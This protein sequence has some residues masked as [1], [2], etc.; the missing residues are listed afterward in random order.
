MEN[1]ENHRI[2]TKPFRKRVE[3]MVENLEALF[4]PEEPSRIGPIMPLIRNVE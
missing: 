1:R 2:G 3:D 4:K